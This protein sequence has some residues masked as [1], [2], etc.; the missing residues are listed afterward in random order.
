MQSLDQFFLDLDLESVSSP[1]PL[2]DLFNRN[3]SVDDEQVFVSDLL[4]SEQIG[5]V[6]D[7][8]AKIVSQQRPQP[9]VNVKPPPSSARLC[10]AS[11][12]SYFGC[13]RIGIK[14]QIQ[15]NRRTN[16][17]L[18][19]SWP[20]QLLNYQHKVPIYYYPPID[21]SMNDKLTENP[22]Q[23]WLTDTLHP[24]TKT[25][26]EVQ[27]WAKNP[28]SKEMQMVV[29]CNTHPSLIKLSGGSYQEKA[30]SLEEAKW[31]HE[32]LVFGVNFNCTR[33]CFKSELY[34]FVRLR[35]GDIYLESDMTELPFRRSEKRRHDPNTEV[36]RCSKRQLIAPKVKQTPAIKVESTEGLDGLP[37]EIPSLILSESMNFNLNELLN[38]NMF[39]VALSSSEQRQ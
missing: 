31:N 5:H 20:D 34:M 3:M 17:Y 9:P 36:T 37:I 24:E 25:Y 22:S 27:F 13:I 21:E 30:V 7:R 38:L 12:P 1:E 29:G 15:T 16:I 14:T 6:I 10:F 23:L 28:D 19:A 8:K 18:D 39:S 2:E 32:Q 4:K 26:L 35:V 11:L 33:T